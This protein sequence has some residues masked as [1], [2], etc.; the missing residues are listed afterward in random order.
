MCEH[1]SHDKKLISVLSHEKDEFFVFFFKKFFPILPFTCFF[2]SQTHTHTN[3]HT[4]VLF[5]NCKINESNFDD[6]WTR[7]NFCFAVFVI[8][9]VFEIKCESFIAELKIW[10][11]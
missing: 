2:T 3:V 5:L 11:L 1:G 6:N 8:F 10:C 9:F 4:P 7:K